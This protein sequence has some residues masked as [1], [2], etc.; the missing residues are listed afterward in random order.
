MLNQDFVT[1]GLVTVLQQLRK[2][3]LKK[4]QFVRF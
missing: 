1:A 4:P 2:C 3:F